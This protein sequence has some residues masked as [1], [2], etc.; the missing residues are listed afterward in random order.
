MAL[1][2]IA[3]WA[4]NSN[5]SDV[6]VKTAFQTFAIFNSSKAYQNFLASGSKSID[7]VS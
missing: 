2:C 7:A 6:E 1:V 4:R 3:G 5:I